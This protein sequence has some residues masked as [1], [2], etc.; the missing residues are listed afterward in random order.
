MSKIEMSGYDFGRI[1]RACAKGCEKAHYRR[2]L[3][4][5]ELRADGKHCVAT[6]LDGYIVQQIK[7]QCSGEGVVLLPNTIKPP[8]CETVTIE[9]SGNIKITFTD[10]G[11]NLLYAFE[12]PKCGER[13]FDWGNIVKDDR[14]ED[15]IHCNAAYLRRAL[16]AT[17]YAD[18]QVISISVPKDR[19]QPIRIAANDVQM[20]VMPV[21]VSDEAYRR[22]FA[23]WY[24]P[25]EAEHESN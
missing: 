16:A 22:N 24:I 14:D 3:R 25:Q 21:R 15:V 4:Y 7:V 10:E 17:T 2:V 1:L 5:I 19:V 13:F 20:I 8:K 18:D 6:S 9:V 23:N 12:L 11:G